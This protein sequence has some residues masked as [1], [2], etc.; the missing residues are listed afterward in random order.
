MFDETIIYKKTRVNIP[1]IGVVW[2]R[3]QALNTKINSF[4]IVNKILLL[5][6]GSILVLTGLLIFIFIDIWPIIAI[7]PLGPFLTVGVIFIYQENK[8]QKLTK[9]LQ[10]V[11]NKYSE[12]IR[13]GQNK[14]TPDI[15]DTRNYIINETSEGKWEKMTKTI[16][17]RTL[18]S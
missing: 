13:V 6:L 14:S 3:M 16:V 17:P 10:I 9:K 5:L 1:E 11:S 4:K 8:I 2:L 18:K 12:L 15:Q 7:P